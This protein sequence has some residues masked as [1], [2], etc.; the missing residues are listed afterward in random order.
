MW[1]QQF[2]VNDGWKIQCKINR[3]ISHNKTI[4]KGWRKVQTTNKNVVI[5]RK[6]FVPFTNYETR[7]LVPSMG[8]TLNSRKYA[9]RAQQVHTENLDF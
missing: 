1:K 5:E 4:R 9:A 2:T 8:Q 3:I 6:I 7:F